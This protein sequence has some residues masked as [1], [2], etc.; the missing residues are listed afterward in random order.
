MADRIILHASDLDGYLTEN[1]QKELENIK[2][3]YDL[4]LDCCN[5][6]EGGDRNAIK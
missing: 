2:S 1:D 5:R 3:M 6:I 4:S